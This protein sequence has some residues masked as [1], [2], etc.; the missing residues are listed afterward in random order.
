MIVLIFFGSAEK[1]STTSWT[2]SWDWSSLNL[3]STTCF[4]TL[5]GLLVGDACGSSAYVKAGAALITE[6]T[7]SSPL[8]SICRPLSD[9]NTPRLL[10]N[11]PRCGIDGEVQV[12]A[13][14]RIEQKTIHHFVKR[15]VP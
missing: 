9:V 7:T 11:M 1:A 4:S 15:L 6:V 5:P 14:I 10:H 12:L 3:Y 8:K 2:R 13:I